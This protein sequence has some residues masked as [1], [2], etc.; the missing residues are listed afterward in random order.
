[1][2]VTIGTTTVSTATRMPFQRLCFYHNGRYWVFY[3]DGTNFVYRTSTDGAAWSGTTTLHA[4]EL[5][6]W[7]SIVFD[8]TYVHYAV[9]TWTATDPIYYR[10]GTP[11]ADG[12]I[13]WSAAE[14]TAVAGDVSDRYADPTIAIDS[15]GYPFIAYIREYDCY[16]AKASTNDGTWTLDWDVLIKASGGD[17]VFSAVV[18]LT[19]AKMYVV[20]GEVAGDT[21]LYGKLYNAGFGGE[22]GVS[23]SD[24]EAAMGVFSVTSIGDDVHVAFLKDTTSDILYVARAVGWGAEETVEA[25]TTV[26]SSPVISHHGSTIYVLWAGSPTADHIYYR[27]RNGAWDSDVDWLDESGQ[28]LTRNDSLSCYFSNFGNHLGVIWITTPGSPYNVRHDELPLLLPASGAQSAFM[29]SKLSAA[30][31]I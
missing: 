4:G 14:Q 18:E 30:G 12:G 29:A 19:S 2:A 20:Y 22:E 7:C 15:N 6:A 23:T 1:M 5:S 21:K 11:D 26:T 13:T 28:G 25:G 3:G 10:R 9:T 16:C 24:A 31:V 17:F 27:V 8:G